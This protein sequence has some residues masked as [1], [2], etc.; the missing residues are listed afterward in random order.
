MSSFLLTDKHTLKYHHHQRSRTLTIW[1][2]APNYMSLKVK[3]WNFYPP[4]WSTGLSFLTESNLNSIF[5]F[6]GQKSI[7]KLCLLLYIGI[8]K[9]NIVIY[10]LFYSPLH[11][12]KTFIFHRRSRVGGRQKLKTPQNRLAV[13][14]DSLSCLCN[15][16]WVFI[17]LKIGYLWHFSTKI[18]I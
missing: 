12:L 4:S 13:Y 3:G 2:Y 5:Q 6:G 16:T 9:N 18:M 11:I 14:P 8:R 10:W 1:S 15:I 17:Y 7:S